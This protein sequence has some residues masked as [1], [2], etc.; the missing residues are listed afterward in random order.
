MKIRIFTLS[1]VLMLLPLLSVAV[2]AASW[3]LD[4]VAVMIDEGKKVSLKVCG[5]MVGTLE[6]QSSD[7]NVAVV[8]SKGVVRGRSHGD[9]V[10]KAVC[11][12][13]G[14]SAE[15]LVSVGYDGQNP[16][17]P[18]TWNLFIADGEPRVINGRMYLFGSRD[19]YDGVGKDGIYEWCSTDYHLIWSD[20]LIHWT[21]AGEILHMDDIPEEMRNGA[22][23]LWAP[24]IFQDPK[25]GKF[26]LTMCTNKSR[27][28]IFEADRPEGPYKNPRM[29]TLNGEPWNSID[30]GVL[31]DDDGKV[32]IALPKFI[33][34]QLDPDDYSH[35]LPESV[36]HLNEAMPK[37]NEP[38]EG[39]SLRKFGDTYYYIYIQ[40][41]GKVAER[42]ACPTRMAYLT[43]KS[44]LGPYEYGGLILS[45]Y[46]Y[47]DAGNV[48]G[49]IEPFHDKWYVAYHRSVPGLHFTRVA[50]M[51]PLEF[52]EDG[53]IKE[54]RMSSSGVRGAFRMG[55][56]IQASSAVEFSEGRAGK[57]MFVIRAGA[58][59]AT[60][61]SGMTDYPFIR[62]SEK[63]QW[64]G[65]CWMDFSPKISSVAVSVSS[66][67]VGGRLEIRRSSADGELLATV[68][69]PHTDGQWQVVEVPVRTEASERDSFYV[70]ATDVPAS[71]VVE[72]DWLR[73]M[74]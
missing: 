28:I 24:D 64:T 62:F 50:C 20:D 68:E 70:V 45:T 6:W 69:V 32:Y 63:G 17:L 26:Y 34:A 40:N 38:F 44:P 4:R 1:V 74:K 55:D 31:V 25:S 15:C 67:A 71:G 73:F 33:V 29:I 65:Y 35:I 60:R 23:R 72:V 61:P 5:E 27:N 14:E 11:T 58:Q 52:A 3:K 8:N 22:I 51:D 30:P 59:D 46:H 36:R 16:L 57:K 48:H 37:D 21:D 13:T 10:I 41:V 18:P 56:R 66:T 43:S 12:E 19:N 9:A 49:S 7:E 39:P 47:P 53:T 2:Q 42:G 54:V